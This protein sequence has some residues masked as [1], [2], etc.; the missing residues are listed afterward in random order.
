MFIAALFV[1]NKK[2]EAAQRSFGG[3]PVKQAV[4]HQHCG[5]LLSNKMEQAT[6]TCNNLVETLRNYAERKQADPTR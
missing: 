2:L 3:W 4:V 1:N 6:D 5:P